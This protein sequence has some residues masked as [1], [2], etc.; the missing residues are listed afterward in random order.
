MIHCC[1]KFIKYIVNLFE[2]FNVGSK[3]NYEIATG[4]TQVTLSATLAIT[5]L[6]D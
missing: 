6:L 1:Q 5:F 4:G 2:N 3:I